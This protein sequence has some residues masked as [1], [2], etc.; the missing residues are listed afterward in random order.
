[1]KN[2]LIYWFAF[3]MLVFQCNRKPWRGSKNP[4][5]IFCPYSAISDW[6]T[7]VDK[8]YLALGDLDQIVHLDGV[9]ERLWHQCA[10]P[11]ESWWELCLHLRINH[12][13]YK[14]YR[15]IWKKNQLTWSNLNAFIFCGLFYC[16]FS[17]I[18]D[19]FICHISWQ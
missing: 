14:F 5:K 9:W 3:L 13:L 19:Y 11:W 4:V 16:W 6:N 12:I 10:F 8:V 17:S 7:S 15:V 18:H 2:Y 1:M